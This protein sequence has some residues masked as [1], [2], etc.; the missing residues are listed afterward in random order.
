[1]KCTSAKLVKDEVVCSD[2][3]AKLELLEALY[4]SKKGSLKIFDEKGKE[5]SWL[6]VIVRKIKQNPNLWILFSVYYDLTERGR[7]V[8]EGPFPSTLELLSDNRAYA[9]VYVIEETIKFQVK[10]IA[11]WLD[12]SRRLEKEMILAIVD[13]H[14]DVSYYSVERFT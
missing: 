4:K 8:R 9:L 3:E 1:L 6:D 11:E 12:V 2:S 5:I 10:Q 13:K 14:G 7:K